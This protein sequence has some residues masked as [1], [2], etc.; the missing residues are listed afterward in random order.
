MVSTFFLGNFDGFK[1]QTDGLLALLAE[2]TA[3]YLR[4][5]DEISQNEYEAS[6]LRMEIVGGGYFGGVAPLRVGRSQDLFTVTAYSAQVEDD[7]LDTQWVFFFGG[8]LA[9]VALLSSGLH[10]LSKFRDE[11]NKKSNQPN[12]T[13]KAI[14][15]PNNK[16]N[17]NNLTKA[18]TGASSK[19]RKWGFTRRD[20]V[21]DSTSRSDDEHNI[22]F[23]VGA[24]PDSDD[25]SLSM[26]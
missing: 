1:L 23:A 5:Q 16:S 21:P 12:A 11:C 8:C 4:W 9:L 19:G 14:A 15:V 22:L 3:F 25:D 17:A 24:P 18:I 7:S 2:L 10:R 26:I 20:T 6:M 13:T